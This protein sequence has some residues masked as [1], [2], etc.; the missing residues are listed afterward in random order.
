VAPAGSTNPGKASPKSGM[1]F[2]SQTGQHHS[3]R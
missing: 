1:R 3:R 2:T